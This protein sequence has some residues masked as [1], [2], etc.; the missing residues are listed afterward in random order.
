MWLELSAGWVIFF[1]QHKIQIDDAP[2]VCQDDVCEH[3]CI[4]A[5]KDFSGHASGLENKGIDKIE[6]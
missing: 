3:K 1:C 4:Q 2:D 5:E 6:Q